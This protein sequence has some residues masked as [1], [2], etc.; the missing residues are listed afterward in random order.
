[1][2]VGDFS[3][4][5]QP[6]VFVRGVGVADVE[7]HGLADADSVGDDQGAGGAVEAVEVAD[8]EVTPVEVVLVLVHDQPDVRPLAEEFL[9]AGGQFV[10]HFLDLSGV[11]RLRQGELQ[12]DA[13][14]PWIQ[15]A[16]RYESKFIVIDFVVPVNDAR[17][18]P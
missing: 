15:L 4:Q 7:L 18:N 1:M 5:Q 9:V 12:Q 17:A 11:L 6:Q 10:E 14:L 16:G 3:S 2:P 8:E 13:R